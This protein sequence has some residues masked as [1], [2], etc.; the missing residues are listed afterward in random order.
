L[1]N[2]SCIW[3]IGIGYIV[4]VIWVLDHFNSWKNYVI[5]IYYYYLIFEVLTCSANQPIATTYIGGRPRSLM[6]DQNDHSDGSSFVVTF[7]LIHQY[8]V[9]VPYMVWNCVSCMRIQY[10]VFQKANTPG[11]WARRPRLDCIQG[12]LSP[13]NI[14]KIHSCENIF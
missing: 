1:K 13:T 5:I 11:K 3:F 14:F 4:C 9:P 12:T 6:N 7:S 8:T 10:S 2:A